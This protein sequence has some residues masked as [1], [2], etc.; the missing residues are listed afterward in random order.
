MKLGEIQQQPKLTAVPTAPKEGMTEQELRVF[1]AQNKTVIMEYVSQ[2]SKE[3]EALRTKFERDGFEKSLL[4]AQANIDQMIK[5]SE[6][7]LAEVKK[8]VG[9]VDESA[10]TALNHIGGLVQKVQTSNEALKEVMKKE[11]ESLAVTSRRAIANL[12]D[13]AKTGITEAIR[14]IDGELKEVVK[15]HQKIAAT[16]QQAY[17][18]QG[19][20]IIG[21]YVFKWALFMMAMFICKRAFGVEGITSWIKVFTGWALL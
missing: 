12:G 18:W 21:G 5:Y 20:W 6:Q 8:L 2:V 1:L 13:E 7:A 19:I 4:A 10:K 3:H 11:A 14:G 17:A 9:T 16:V 15:T